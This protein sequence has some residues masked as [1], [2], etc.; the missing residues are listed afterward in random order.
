MT[1]VEHIRELLRD[2]GYP[3][4]PSGGP[5]EYI[6][7]GTAQVDPPRLVLNEEAVDERLRVLEP[8]SVLVFG[9]EDD[10]RRGARNLFVLG[11]ESA[12]STRSV[13]RMGYSASGPINDVSRRPQASSPV[14]A[15][16]DEDFEWVADPP[17]TEQ[18]D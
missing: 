6:L 18:S 3:S 1:E 13:R 14:T 17:R 8:E 5:D 11:I 2:A 9:E 10:R 4:R 15:H 12:L 7:D 16:P